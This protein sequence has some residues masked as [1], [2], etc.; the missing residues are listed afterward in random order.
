MLEGLVA[1]MNCFY[2]GFREMKG[3]DLVDQV[4]GEV[5]KLI[6]STMIGCVALRN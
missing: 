6:P 1:F 3:K 4:S 2:C 5:D